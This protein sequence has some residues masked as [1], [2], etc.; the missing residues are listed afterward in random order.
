MTRRS[1]GLTARIS[2][3]AIAAGTAF[4]V[5][6]P[7][8]AQEAE[9]ATSELEEIVV[10]GALTDLE[11]NRE[12]IELIQA[13]DLVDLFRSTPSVA[14]GGSIGIAQK[15]YVRGLEDSMLN[16]TVDGAPQRGTLF[17]HIG[18]V[19]LEPE[20]LQSV[21][22][23]TGAG[24]A[25]S[26][27]GAI[28]G[29]I[30]FRT[31]DPVNLLVDDRQFGGMARL[32][33]FSNDGSKYSLTGY[34][35]LFGDVG[36]LASYVLVDRNNFEDGDGNEIPA[37]GARQEMLFLKAGGELGGG[38]RLTLSYEQRDEEASFAQRPNWPV[39]AG[40]AV[41][42]GEARRRTFTG[43]YGYDINAD[44][45]LEATAYHTETR[46]LQDRTDRWGLYGSEITSAGADVRLTGR[47]GGHRIIG[48]V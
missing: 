2:A 3:A 10:V 46:F 45:E 17:H 14:V 41:F 9:P 28:G 15:I 29:A 34:G 43:N 6:Q 18:R 24:E 22:V 4:A 25:T 23:Q 38:H 20:L 13:N 8:S 26:G 44:L 31:V 36:V 47:Y 5:A 30:R 42:P 7:A 27:F 1:S 12:E 37:S 19:S 21:D 48:G 33:W 40:N 16:V 35:R 11:L 39:V 32:G